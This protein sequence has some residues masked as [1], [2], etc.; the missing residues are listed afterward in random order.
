MATSGRNAD[1][2]PLILE[3]SFADLAYQYDYRFEKYISSQ[4]VWGYG[5]DN[6]EA[7]GRDIRGQPFYHTMC[8]QIRSSWIDFWSSAE[9][10]FIYSSSAGSNVS[11]SYYAMSMAQEIY[12]S[13]R[14]SRW[15]GF[16]LR[17]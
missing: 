2:Q 13:A 3:G 1:N 6:A 11:Q 9:A 15:R 16:S 17:R 4:P 8:G 10:G 7:I 12:P 5:S 14:D